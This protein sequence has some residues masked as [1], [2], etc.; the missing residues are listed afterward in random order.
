MIPLPP[1]LRRYDQ[2][3]WNFSSGRLSSD[4]VEECFPLRKIKIT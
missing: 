2:L 1:L 4:F 3:L